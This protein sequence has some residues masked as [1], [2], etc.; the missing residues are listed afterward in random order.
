MGRA[1]VA[2]YLLGQSDMPTAAQDWWQ[3]AYLTPTE[4]RALVAKYRSH[5]KGRMLSRTRI[6]DWNRIP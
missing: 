5:G 3:F 2:F 6:R 4:L 1:T